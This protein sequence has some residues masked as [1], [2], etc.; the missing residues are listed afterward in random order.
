[1]RAL[2]AGSTL[3][4]LRKVALLAGAV[5]LTAASCGGGGDETGA[6]AG[7]AVA[8]AG[9]T[10]ASATAEQLADIDLT[11]ALLRPRDFPDPDAVEPILLAA[12]FGA[13]GRGQ[14]IK[15]CGQ[16]LRADV[17]ADTGRFSQFRVDRYAVTQTI[18]AVP[19]PQATALGQR[20]AAL[21]RT[22]TQPWTQPDPNG[23]SITR[24]I[25]GPVPLPDLGAQAAAYLVRGENDL[26]RDDS[27]LLMVVDGPYVSTLTVTGPVDDRFELV[28]PLELALAERL[29][30]LPAP[31]GE[32]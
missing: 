31:G 19:E 30:A 24:R 15:V 3:P 13:V 18:T 9:P 32:A 28:E 11:P 26:G 14:R 21:G 17:G 7:A 12:D 29:R 23:G 2:P 1:M 6:A 22:C 5:A 16:D 25:L 27:I 20:F 4:R 10:S 8:A